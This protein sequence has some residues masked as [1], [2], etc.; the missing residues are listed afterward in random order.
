MLLLCLLSQNIWRVIRN[1]SFFGMR[2][3]ETDHLSKSAR[4]GLQMSS[5]HAIC[6]VAQN[7]LNEWSH[8]RFGN[9][10]FTCL[11]DIFKGRC[12]N[13]LDHQ[14]ALDLKSHKTTAG[15][16][17]NSCCCFCCVV[18]DLARKFLLRKCLC[19]L[20]EPSQALIHLI[21]TPLQ[22]SADCQK[23]RDYKIASRLCKCIKFPIPDKG[24]Y[25]NFF[26]SI[27]HTFVSK[28]MQSNTLQIFSKYFRQ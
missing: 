27:M 7:I 19:C 15:R 10:G 2:H 21:K 13:V 26:S 1:I 3:R 5:Q 16:S 9:G 25:C 23:N 18:H 6:L 22:F 8:P 28:T 4:T 24:N 14:P 12:V 17:S 11:T 20:A